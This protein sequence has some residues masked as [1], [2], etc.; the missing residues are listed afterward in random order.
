MTV[1]GATALART[2][3]AAGADRQLSGLRTCLARARVRWRLG[4]VLR[5]VIWSLLFGLIVLCA[6]EA[7]TAFLDGWAGLPA[8]SEHPL[9]DHLVLCVTAFACA[10]GLAVFLTFLLTPDL[11]ALARVADRT[12]A[13]QERLSTALEVAAKLRSDSAVDP[14]RAAL[15]ADAEQRAGAIDPRELVRLRLPH[16]VW[17]VPA[18]IAAAILLQVVPPD[19][20][21]RTAP[22]SSTARDVSDDGP[23][24]R[25]QA[26]DT[27]ANLRRIAEILQQD[28]TQRSDPYLRTIARTLDRL[29]TEVAQ[30]TMDR[31]QLASELDRLLTHA[32]QAYAQGDRP[33][34]QAASRR[35]PT[36]LLRSA[37][38]D[39]TG[40]RQAGSAPARDRDREAPEAAA[41]ER[42]PAGRPVQ[43]A[44]RREAG[45]R[46][47]SEQIA[48][49][50]RLLPGADIQWLYVD[51]DGNETDPRAQIE[52]LMA[53][54]ER[55][56][57][58]GAQPAGAAANAGQGEGDRAGDGV[59]PLGRGNP[60]KSIDLAATEQMLLP[61]PERRDGGRIRIEIPPDAALSDVVAPTS[62]ASGGWR[63]VQEQTVERPALAAEGRRIVGRYF[64]RAT[65]GRGP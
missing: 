34:G 5:G 55:R 52:R 50:R 38:D 44:E 30:A 39:I 36:E 10:L 3:A 40:N 32:Q 47:Q 49:L 65:E 14:V 29:S 28:A 26:A 4:S 31:R 25:Q 33:A 1:N 41:A 37:L 2:P 15:L 23:L 48:A 42:A 11:P 21:G 9:L 43:R 57:R 53:E 51:E 54:E 64:K 24:S 17:A 13:L 59:Q 45:S 35:D 19:A 56:A 58:A 61:D 16:A 6:L 60:A 20:F 22:G 12:F 46:T 62:D 7:M 8:M 18:L 63:R 27:A